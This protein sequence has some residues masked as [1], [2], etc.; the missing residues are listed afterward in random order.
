MI[1]L[2]MVICS[3]VSGEESSLARC[4][5]TSKYSEPYHVSHANFISYV[6][7]INF[8]ILLEQSLVIRDVSALFL[9]EVI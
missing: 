7:Y 9:Y 8:C 1:K 6:N 4:G 3:G 5:K 2:S